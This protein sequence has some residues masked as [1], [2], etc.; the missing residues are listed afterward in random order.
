M[1]KRVQP[2]RQSI[3]TDQRAPVERLERFLLLRPSGEE[4][5]S[6]GRN[7][8]HRGVGVLGE[9]EDVAGGGLVGRWGDEGW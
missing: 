8:R 1:I 4:V 5:V 2:S 9:L 6:C 7:K 3:P